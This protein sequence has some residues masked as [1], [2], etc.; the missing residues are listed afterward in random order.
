M[1]VDTSNILILSVDPL[2]F[3]SDNLATD[4]FLQNQEDSHFPNTWSG[5]Q[6]ILKRWGGSPSGIFCLNQEAK[7]TPRPSYVGFR[8]TA[9]EPQIFQTTVWN[10]GASDLSIQ[11]QESSDLPK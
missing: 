11:K 8:P 5:A 1:V 7:G 2:N 6:T 9:S 10:K 3:V 4:L